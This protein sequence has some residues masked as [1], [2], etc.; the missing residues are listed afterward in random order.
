VS[1]LGLTQTRDQA[2]AL[3]QQPQVRAASDTRLLPE[4]CAAI[5]NEG[6]ASLEHQFLASTRFPPGR[7]LE[8]TTADHQPLPHLKAAATGHSRTHAHVKQR[9]RAFGRDRHAW[10]A[11]TWG[12]QA[13]QPDPESYR[14]LLLGSGPD[15]G[16]RHRAS[17]TIMP[18]IAAGSVLQ[19]S[20]VVYPGLPSHPAHGRAQE[21]FKQ[22]FGGMLCFE[23]KG[24]I[25]ATEAFMKALTL[26]LSAPR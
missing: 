4:L 19:I 3:K 20:K 5:L 11:G 21:L 14:K 23:V 15:S 10:V 17:C 24:S 7:T 25:A 6:K 1:G 26:P 16:R 8:M 9:P 13:G 22:G 18:L 2:T 12:M